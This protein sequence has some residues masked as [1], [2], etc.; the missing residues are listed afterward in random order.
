MRGCRRMGRSKEACEQPFCTTSDFPRKSSAA[1]NTVRGSLI[2]ARR[3]IWPALNGRANKI[4]SWGYRPSTCASLSCPGAIPIRKWPAGRSAICSRYSCG[5]RWRP[6]ESRSFFVGD[7]YSS[8]TSQRRARSP[9]L[10]VGRSPKCLDV[11][12]FGGRRAAT[13]E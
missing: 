2:R 4:Q 3:L 13:G 7:R 1:A 6:W 11:E 10:A 9:G 8:V 12:Q 5:S